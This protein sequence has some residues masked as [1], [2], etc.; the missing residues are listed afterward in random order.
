[1]I[2]SRAPR[3]A[4]LG[5]GL[6]HLLACW[7]PPAL[8][9]EEHLV[10][11][12]LRLGGAGVER[13]AG[14]V[15][16]PS[17]RLVGDAGLVLGLDDAELVVRHPQ[18]GLIPADASGALAFDDGEGVSY[19]ASWAFAR[20]EPGGGDLWVEVEGAVA[21]LEML[22]W[23]LLR[24]DAERAGQSRFDFPEDEEGARRWVRVG[25]VAM[26]RA[27]EYR[28]LF[29]MS[30]DR[31]RFHGA[32]L[33]PAGL[34]PADALE[35]PRILAVD[36]GEVVSAAVRLP[37]AR[38]VTGV[39]AAGWNGQGEVRLELAFGAGDWHWAEGGRLP[40]SLQEK[41][42]EPGETVRARA[43]AVL[44]RTDSG[45]PRISGIAL[46]VEKGYWPVLESPE[47][48]VHLDHSG[49][50]FRIRDRIEGRDLVRFTFPRLAG[51]RL[52]ANGFDDDQLRMQ[53]FGHL[54]RA[55]GLA[56]VRDVKYPGSLAL[57]WEAVDDAE[58]GL[59]LISLD[60]SGRNLGFSSRPS[61]FFGDSYD[62][63]TT[64]FPLHLHSG[65]AYRYRIEYYRT[66]G[67]SELS[68]ALVNYHLLDESGDRHA[69]PL[70][71]ENKWAVAEGAFTVPGQAFSAALY[72][73]NWRSTRTLWVRD[74]RIEGGAEP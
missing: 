49:G 52:G 65:E 57:P 9:A 28:L 13:G 16:L 18:M 61:G 11:L 64:V 8:G 5:L 66:E 43:R 7:A 4:L 45:A 59:A 38:A 53:T 35:P 15:G 72:L 36:E 1:M 2:F 67:E 40:Q 30:R 23:T 62:L 14:E 3:T 69:I 47:A 54:R 6:F 12:P 33:L 27:G 41:E 34:D 10:G 20:E 44:R 71:A 46:R 19:L 56:P 39:E 50:I 60:P 32:A 63:E 21:G 29:R 31:C 26:D 68:L 70:P 73:Y 24:P 22:L 48:V 51:I 74:I 58:G 42:R 25:E 55:P 37:D 17:E